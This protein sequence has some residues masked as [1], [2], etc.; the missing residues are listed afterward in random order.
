[1]ANRNN[2][3]RPG[4]ALVVALV[5]IVALAGVVVAT[6]PAAASVPA[7]Y[8]ARALGM[9]GAYTAVVEDATALYWNPAAIGLSKFSAHA[10]FGAGVPEMTGLDDIK[11]ITGLMGGMEDI[12]DD[13]QKL[14]DVL[15]SEASA[16]AGVGVAAGLNIGSIALGFYADADAT[17]TKLPGGAADANLTM[18]GN[19]GVGIARNIVGDGTKGLFGIRVGAVGRMIQAERLEFEVDVLDQVHDERKSDGKGYAVD[20]GLLVRLSEIVTLGASARNVISDVTWSDGEED[21]LPLEL[22]FGASVQPPLIGMTLAADI[23]PGGSIRYG[24][25]QKLFFGLMRLRAG[26]IRHDEAVWTT[27]G[28]GFALG[29]VALDAAVA[30]KQMKDFSL[31]LEGSF[32]F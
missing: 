19:G 31:G 20:L 11:K 14:L 6:G 22:N 7:V 32:V 30:V 9:G 25:E 28:L 24:I 5:T 3:S 29:P 4:F 27:G 26:Q 2:V 15:S 12:A 17:I 18:Y 13:P 23:S 1:M 21:P 16:A 8:G 10:G